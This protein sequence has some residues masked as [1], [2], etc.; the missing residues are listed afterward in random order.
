MASNFG[1]FSKN[2]W[3]FN[4]E[5]TVIRL[6][7]EMRSVYEHWIPILTNG[8]RVP[9]PKLGL[10]WDSERHRFTDDV[11]PYSEAGLEGRPVYYSNAIIRRLQQA[12]AADPKKSVR[13]IKIPPRFYSHLCNFKGMRPRITKSGERKYYDMSHPVFGFDIQV[14]INPD[15]PFHYYETQL[16]E[17]SKLTAEELAYPL[18]SLEVRPETLTEARREWRKLRGIYAGDQPLNT[19]D[20]VLNWA[21]SRIS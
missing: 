13:M 20:P 1:E 16:V 2:V 14:K 18:L 3:K 10:N 21:A 4:A 12:K 11:C 7:G 5:W 17:P 6:I 8:K 9:I 15:N 19:E